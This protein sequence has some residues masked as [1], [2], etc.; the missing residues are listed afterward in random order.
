MRVVDWNINLARQIVLG[1][2]IRPGRLSLGV[3]TFGNGS[4]VSFYLNTYNSKDDILNALSFRLATGPNGLQ[5]ALQALTTDFFTS[6]RGSSGSAPKV[7]VVITSS[8]TPSDYSGI[9]QAA[10]AA[11][12]A[13]IE[14]YAISLGDGPNMAMITSIA[15]NSTANHVFTGSQ[16]GDIGTIAGNLLTILCQ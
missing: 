13:N 12:S 14:I 9:V 10:A 7:A 6:N 3:L 4:S 8:D 2:P 11:R 16:A 15:S 1:L 5:S